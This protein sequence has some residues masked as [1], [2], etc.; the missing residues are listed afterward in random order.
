MAPSPRSSDEQ[1]LV[2]ADAVLRVHHRVA[3]LELRQ[4]ADD[5]IDVGLRLAAPARGAP[6]HAGEELGFGDHREAGGGQLEAVVHRA[7]AQRDLVRRIGEGVP[8]VELRQARAP[9]PSSACSA[10]NCTSVSRRPADSATISLR[11]GLPTQVSLERSRAAARHGDSTDEVGQARSRIGGSARG[12]GASARRR[13]A[14]LRRL[15]H[16]LRRARQRPA[17]EVARSRRRT[18]RRSGTARRDAAAAARRRARGTCSAAR[19]R[20]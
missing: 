14:R 11:S 18:V 16:V 6:H 7:D 2:A 13:L 20:R 1:A 9:S 4:V 5:R 19:R 3:D 17:P 8:V 15:H 12:R 10:K